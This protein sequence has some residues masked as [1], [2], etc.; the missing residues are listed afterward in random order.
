MEASVGLAAELS[1]NTT[2][3]STALLVITTEVLTSLF[4]TRAD[5]S[6]YFSSPL[7]LYTMVDTAV[8]PEIDITYK[9][10]RKF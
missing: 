10:L 5:I 6:M 2:D 7:L 3:F 8:L 4:I 1:L 9:Y